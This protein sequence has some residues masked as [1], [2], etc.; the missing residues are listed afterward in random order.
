MRALV[1]LLSLLAAGPAFADNG[2]DLFDQQCVSCH[3]LMT[4]ST[5]NGPSLKGVVWRKVASLP[6][7]AYTPALTSA[8]GNWTPDRLDQF[9][10]DTQAFAPGTSM[11]FAVQ[12]K[13]ARRAIIK[14]LETLK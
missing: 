6:D 1:F 3:A 5:A 8:I 4:A 7:F 12:D 13:T 10:K 14:Y 2:Q 9:L 11:F